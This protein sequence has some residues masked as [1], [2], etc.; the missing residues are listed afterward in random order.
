MRIYKQ[1]DSQ[2]IIQIHTIRDFDKIGWIRKS[3]KKINETLYE[4]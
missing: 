3:L 1:S 2:A 4:K